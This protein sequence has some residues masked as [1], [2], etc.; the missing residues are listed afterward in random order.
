MKGLRPTAWLD[1]LRGFAALLVYILHHNLWAHEGGE[2]IFENAYGY[3]DR[4][5]F[6]QLPGI[7]VLLAGGHFAVA[8]FF[9]ISGYVLSLKPMTLRQKHKYGEMT[10]NIASALVRR[11]LRLYILVAITTFM[12]MICMSIYPPLQ[13][14]IEPQETFFGE[15]SMWYSDFK[16]FSFVFREGGVPWMHYNFH[17]WT[18]PLE[19]RGSIVIYTTVIALF[20]CTT[21]ARLWIQVLL[22]FYFMYI[23]DG[24]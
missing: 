19:F 22:I 11:W 3:Q 6:V 7:R 5:Y 1:G 8:I 14:M 9:V 23:V 13:P 4:Y 12:F 18:I 10:E 16:Q 2:P 17:A 21:K 20:R 24:W 15:L